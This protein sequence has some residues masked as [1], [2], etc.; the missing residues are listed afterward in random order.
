MNESTD[1]TNHVNKAAWE[2][3]YFDLL[4]RDVSETVISA[5]LRI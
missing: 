2:T 4:T 5:M 1:N 3:D